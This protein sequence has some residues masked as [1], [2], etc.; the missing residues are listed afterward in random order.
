MGG[1]KKQW[2]FAAKTS[3][4]LGT[5]DKQG[6]QVGFFLIS[7]LDINEHSCQVSSIVDQI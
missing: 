1:V 7:D 4:K 2:F 6:E 3:Y 5:D